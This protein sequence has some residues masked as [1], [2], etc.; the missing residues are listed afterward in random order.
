[1]IDAKNISKTFDDFTALDNVSIKV[2]K[3]SIYG[4]LGPNGAGKSTLL[5]ILTGVYKENNGNCLID[6]KPVYENIAIKNK[7]IFLNDELFFFPLSSINSMVDFYSSIYKN[8]DFNRFSELKKI[9]KLD[10]KKRLST[11]SKGMQRQAIFMITLC[12]MPD[13]LIL[14]EPFDGLDPIIRYSIKKIIIN[15]VA[16][17]NMTVLI[18]SHNLRELEDLC[19]HIG[20][21]FKGKLVIEQELDNLKSKLHKIQIA[22]KKESTIKIIENNLTILNKDKHGSINLLIVKGDREEILDI[23]NKYNPILLDILPLTLEEIFIY[24]M[25]DLGYDLE[26][27]LL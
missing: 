19:D 20:I 1:M 25:G 21:L 11:F 26:K 17:R 14:D 2:N 9:F 8:F 27:I 16:N 6:N 13:I 12:C 5:K 15:D 23:L 7:I 10:V 3:G 24:E 22:F 4:L 18:S